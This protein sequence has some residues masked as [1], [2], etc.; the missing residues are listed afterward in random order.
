MMRG[1]QGQIVFK[2]K[3]P[4]SMGYKDDLYAL[5]DVPES[6]KQWLEENFFQSADN[7]ASIALRRMLAGDLQFDND[8]RSSWSRFIMSLMA[9]TPDRIE[10]VRG[11]YEAEIPNFRHSL[12]EAYDLDN[13][14]KVPQPTAEQREAAIKQAI[15]LG[16]G[17]LIQGVMDLPNIG[18]Q[19][20][21]MI[22]NIRTIEAAGGRFF[23]TSDKP[24]YLSKGLQHDDAFFTLPISSTKLFLA[25]KSQAEL[26]R[27][28][29]MSEADIVQAVN[30]TVVQQAIKYVY[31]KSDL[32]RNF[33]FKH[34]R[35]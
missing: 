26:D 32:E 33:V 2:H 18:V 21:G 23:L 10:Y 8:M 15:S 11:A 28:G 3:G 7:D 5:F 35:S 14:G 22:W 12:E 25:S 29:Q 34:L 1:H 4:A 13:I 24:V 17:R 30:K 27:L 16:T 9:R 31:A 20:N 6:L 19:L